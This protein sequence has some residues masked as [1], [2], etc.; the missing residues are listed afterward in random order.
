MQDDTLPGFWRGSIRNTNSCN[1]DRS[2]LTLRPSRINTLYYWLF[3]FTGDLSCLSHPFQDVRK[4]LGL[5]KELLQVVETANVKL[6]WLKIIMIKYQWSKPL[7]IN[8]WCTCRVEELEILHLVWQDS[9]LVCRLGLPTTRVKRTM[10]LV[11]D[12]R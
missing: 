2:C 4:T 7:Y 11:L 1:L 3:S 10:T 9:P 5:K 6:N 8:K 12:I